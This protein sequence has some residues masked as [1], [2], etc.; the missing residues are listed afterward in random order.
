MQKL[1]I[2][3]PR[4]TTEISLREGVWKIVRALLDPVVAAKVD[5]TRNTAELEKHIPRENIPAKFGGDDPWKFEY[6]EPDEDEDACISRSDEREKIMAERNAIAERLLAATRA[7]IRHVDAS[8]TEDAEVQARK[9]DVAIED[10]RRN[11]WVLDP[12]VRSRT[13]LD[14]TG[15]IKPGGVIEL[16]PDRKAIVEEEPTEKAIESGETVAVAREV[17]VAA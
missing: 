6:R 7:W 11:Y 10:L 13:H 17:E 9:R 5:F 15:V 2:L 8:E 16:Y 12:Y 4:R 14:R 3:L 1:P